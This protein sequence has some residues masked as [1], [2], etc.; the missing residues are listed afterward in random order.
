M[1]EDPFPQQ[2]KPGCPVLRVR[3][4]GRRKVGS[5]Q[6]FHLYT[7]TLKPSEADTGARACFAERSAPRRCSYCGRVET[8]ELSVSFFLSFCKKMF[9]QD[10]LWKNL[11]HPHLSRPRFSP[12]WQLLH[13]SVLTVLNTR[14]HLRGVQGIF[15]PERPGVRRDRRRPL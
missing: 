10:S 1:A 9:L 11:A 7:L 15:G 2:R 3:L 6:P 5:V 14:A 4:F 8:D 13:R 12:R